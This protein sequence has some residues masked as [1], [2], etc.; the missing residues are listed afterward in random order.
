[1]KSRAKPNCD[2]EAG[3]RSTS[4]SLVANIAHKTRALL[5]WDAK[6]ERFTNNEAAN[7]WLTYEYRPAFKLP[8]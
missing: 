7:K 4:A 6:A 8:G 2:I 1:V 3:D 5:E